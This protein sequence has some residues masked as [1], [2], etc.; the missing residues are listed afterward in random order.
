MRLAKLLASMK[1]D[2]G[3]VTNPEGKLF[4]TITLESNDGDQPARD[5]DRDGLE[6]VRDRLL[7]L[8]RRVARDL[9]RPGQVG[10]R[11]GGIYNA[12][13]GT[14]F[15]VVLSLAVSP[16]GSHATK[17]ALAFMIV[18]FLTLLLGLASLMRMGD[19]QQASQALSQRWLPQ[20]IAVQ[21]L[22]AD[23]QQLRQLY[24]ASV[25]LEGVAI[26]LL[27]TAAAGV[28]PGDPRAPKTCA[29]GWNARSR[30]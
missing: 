21:A 6:V 9:G 12:R 14:H 30:S 10:S 4:L 26:G 19:I 16:D 5:E 15:R 11:E 7:L 24:G 28:R 17:L 29:L 18:L 1:D 13:E 20:T 2:N 22:R 8:G 25:V 23:L 27:F 3:R